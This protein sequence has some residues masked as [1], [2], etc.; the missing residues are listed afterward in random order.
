MGESFLN[1]EK[2]SR[3][4]NKQMGAK[5]KRTKTTRNGKKRYETKQP[6]K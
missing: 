3:S 6:K 4:Q 2:A 1:K 5:K